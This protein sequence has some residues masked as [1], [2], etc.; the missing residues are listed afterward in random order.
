MSHIHVSTMLNASPERV[1]ELI[2]D[3][4]S[5]KEWM[6]DAEDIVVTSERTQGVGTT[7][8]V[9]TKVGPLRLTD[10]MEITEWEPARSMGVH[11]KGLVTGSGRFV[12]TPAGANRTE[13]AW[14]EDLKFP[15]WMGGPIGG[16][17]GSKVLGWIW[18]RNLEAL[19]ARVDA[20]G[21]A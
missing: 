14:V 20:A 15:L 4:E 19:G 5:H 11:H 12:L 18:R 16:F 3:I 17:F 2:D 6:A 7:F 8:T 10:H 1:W 9:P 13:F 21:R